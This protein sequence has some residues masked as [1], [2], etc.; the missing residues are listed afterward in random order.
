MAAR[1]P[2]APVAPVTMNTATSVTIT[3]TIPYNGGSSVDSYNLQILTSDGA[4]FVEQSTYCNARSDSTVIS[5]RYCAIPMSVLTSEPF[6][7]VQGDEI[8]AQILAHNHLGDSP[9]SAD[10]SNNIGVGAL[11]M[12]VP[13]EPPT[14]AS[15][16]SLTTTDQIQAVIPELEG[17]LTGGSPIISY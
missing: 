12:Q 15:R 14:G 10:S 4:T 1:H 8:V 5:N 2:D 3:W 9:Y 16:G 6:L 17:A 13:H 11:I 7:L